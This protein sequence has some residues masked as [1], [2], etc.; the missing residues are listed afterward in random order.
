M[1]ILLLKDKRIS[2]SE[3]IELQAQFSEIY[4]EL[5]PVFFV[6][7]TD[8]SDYPTE[9]DSD[10]DVRPSD[11]WTR[12]VTEDIYKRYSGE[13]TDHV[14]FLVHEDNWKS[15]PDGPNNGIWG[16]NYSNKYSGYQVHYCRFDR[17]NM[18]NSIGT[19]YHEVMHSHD[20]LIYKYTGVEID[21]I[22]KVDDWDLSVVH[23]QHKDRQYIRHT[24]NQ[25]DLAKITPYL[26]LA[27][28]KR[29]TLYEDKLTKMATIISLAEKFLTLY[30]QF[31][32]KK[33]KY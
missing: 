32:Y 25:D 11:K 3:L 4:S 20:A 13:G 18:A 33:K 15:D 16:I 22:L 8:Y 29:A 23:G 2:D 21:N 5:K 12:E 9:L 28:A 10:G 7:D 31:K 27:Y 19:L 26:K 1:K 6:E 17:D 24:E 14:V 30:R